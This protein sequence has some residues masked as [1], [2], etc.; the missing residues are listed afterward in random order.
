MNVEV[1]E[2]CRPDTHAFSNVI[3]LLLVIWRNHMDRSIENYWE[4]RLGHLKEEEERGQI[5]S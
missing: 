2:M 4:A 3:M 5:Y 1:C